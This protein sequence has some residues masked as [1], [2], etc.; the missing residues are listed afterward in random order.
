[1]SKIK[2]N[3]ITLPD[4]PYAIDALEPV[5]SAETLKFHHSKHHKAYVENTARLIEGTDF[6]GEELLTVINR[7]AGDPAHAA[8]FNN[9]AQVYN[10]SFYWQCMKPNGGGEPEG[11]LALRIE[12]DFGG[13]EK[14]SETFI[15]AATTLFGSGWVW[16]VLHNSKLEILKTTNADTPIIYGH[17]PLLTV[18]VWEHAY[19][20][21]YRNRRPEYL[22]LWVEKLINWDFVN[23]NLG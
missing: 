5:I 16:L 20:I 10:H 11:D 8:L 1:M 19:Y 4:L 18:D 6:E 22:R 9:A 2:L 21:D 13:Y 17:T 7:S 3:T 23:S 15:E 14:F 12:A